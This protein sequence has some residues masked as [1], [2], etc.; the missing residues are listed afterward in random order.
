M[1]TEFEE[2]IINDDNWRHLKDAVDSLESMANF[3]HLTESQR[4]RVHTALKLLI[5]VKEDVWM[6]RDDYFRYLN[7]VESCRP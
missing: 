7:E 6:L 2:Y 3:T 5:P 1:T 4:N